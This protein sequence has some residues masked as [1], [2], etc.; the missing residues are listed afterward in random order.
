MIIGV[1]NARSSVYAKMVL[2]VIIKVEC[3][4]VPLDGLAFSKFLVWFFFFLIKFIN[5]IYMQL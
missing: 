1:I 5:F 2:Y 4:I 3:V